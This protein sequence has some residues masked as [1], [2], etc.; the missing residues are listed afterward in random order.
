VQSFL[1]IPALKASAPTQ[2]EAPFAV[3]QL[4]ALILFAAVGF[5]AVR[6]F[7]TVV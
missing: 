5:L 6:K 7:R 3:A 2:T 1:K 4:L